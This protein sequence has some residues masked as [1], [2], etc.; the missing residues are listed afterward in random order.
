ML[1]ADK[2]LTT[3]TEVCAYA[4]RDGATQ[5]GCLLVQAAHILKPTFSLVYKCLMTNLEMVTCNSFECT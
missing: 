4:E 1:S 5:V 3:N 2:L